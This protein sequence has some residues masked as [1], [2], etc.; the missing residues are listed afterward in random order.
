[1]IRPT[2]STLLATALLAGG[3][4]AQSPFAKA[5][6]ATTI[7]YINVPDIDSTLADFRTMPMSKM[8][9]E[10][11]VQDF[12]AQ[13]LGMAQ[14]QIDEGLGMARAMYEDGQLPVDPDT[15]MNLRVK[16]AGFALTSMRAGGNQNGPAPEFG[17]VIHV[18]FGESAQLWQQLLQIGMGALGAETGRAPEPIE[19][20]D[21]TLMSIRPE[22]SSPMG[23]HFTF[24][25]E[26][27]IL[28]TLAEEV[29]AVCT[30]L[31]NADATGLAGSASF[32]G[33]AQRLTM[34]GAET[35]FFFRPQPALDFVLDM[36][37]LAAEVAPD[38][39]EFIDIDGIERVIDAFG[40]RT[41]QSITSVSRYENGV[42]ISETFTEAP[43]E[44]RK[45]LYADS[46]PLSLDFLRWVPKEAVAFDAGGFDVAG[47][48]D[49]LMNAVEAYDPN[50]KA[51]VEAEMGG[52]EEQIGLSL[53]ND[54]FGAFGDQYVFWRM[55]LAGLAMT[56]P[57]LA[58]LVEMKDA[59]GFL[60]TM[61]VIEQASGGMVALKPVQRR[62]VTLYQ[63]RV[64][65]DLNDFGGIN[66]MDFLT[67]TFTFKDGYLVAALSTNDVLTW[68]RRMDREDEPSGDVRSN[69]QFAGYFDK[70]VA[71][72]SFDS[73]SFTDWKADFASTY[74]MAVGL[75]AMLLFDDSIPFEPALLPE[76]STLTQHLFGGLSFSRTTE[77]GFTSTSM[78][79]FGPELVILGGAAIGAGAA[80][81][82]L[83][84]GEDMAMPIEIK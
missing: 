72:Q 43:A 38:F 31:T 71:G 76:A 53:K 35:E 4:V 13:A 32:A 41:V 18:D 59:D 66:P 34:G 45:G 25:G 39:P 11:E 30:N 62:D 52:L 75:S 40:L 61:S 48:Y 70:Y 1:M 46:D 8:W 84:S 44:K 37:R 65:L 54:L 23:V 57:E 24:Q 67:P 60:K 12:F 22:P 47:L 50:M 7:G 64:E 63:L 49:M 28:G 21:V 82:G 74:Q 10:P 73:L 26:S 5:L 6:P 42:A 17:V 83:M 14:E 81:F 2:L 3:T 19:V 16:S 29:G 78:G 51:M 33:A 9:Q 36:A 79:P 27:L 69:P 68:S 58:V 80:V 20:G 15:L 56:S 55:P 77:D